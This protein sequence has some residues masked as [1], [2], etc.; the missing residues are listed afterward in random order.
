MLAAAAAFLL[1]IDMTQVIAALVS[2]SRPW[3]LA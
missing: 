3:W 1:G 2:F